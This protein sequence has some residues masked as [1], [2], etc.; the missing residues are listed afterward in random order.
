MKTKIVLHIVCYITKQKNNH[1]GRLSVSKNVEA[2][3]N[4][5]GVDSPSNFDG[6]GTFENSNE[7]CVNIFGHSE[8]KRN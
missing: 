5:E 2:K 1:G 3:H 4:W 8:E 6:V 7:I